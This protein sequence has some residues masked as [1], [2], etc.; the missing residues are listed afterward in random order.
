MAAKESQY[1]GSSGPKHCE[2]TQGMQTCV[3]NGIVFKNTE[4]LSSNKIT[5]RIY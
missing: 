4:R 2:Q 1:I 5:I 3:H